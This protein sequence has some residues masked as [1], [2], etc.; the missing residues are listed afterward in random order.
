MPSVITPISIP[1]QKKFFDFTSSNN[2]ARHFMSNGFT[3]RD[4]YSSSLQEGKPT[5]NNSA[6]ASATKFQFS[7]SD[8]SKFLICCFM[9]YLSSSLSSNT[10]KHIMNMFKFPVTLTFTQFFFVACH[11]FLHNHL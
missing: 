1:P 10:G 5:L 7:L 8:N 9:W 6:T 3:R 11:V 2:H 4:H